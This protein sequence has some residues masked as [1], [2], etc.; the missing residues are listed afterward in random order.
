LKDAKGVLVSNVTTGSAAEKAGIKRG[1]IITAI[2]GEAIEDSNVL[3]NKVAG[4]APGTEIKV[5]V[6]RDGNPQDFTAKLD[7]FNVKG[8]K[9]DLPGSEDEETPREQKET[10]KLGLSLQPV[11]PQ[12]AKQLE[13]P[14]DTQGM[15]VMEVDPD[16]ASAEEGIARGDVILEINRQPVKSPEDVQAALDKSGNRPI[17]LLVTR[18]GTTVYLTVTPKQ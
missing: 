13:L 2:N 9:S 17:L 4:S 7:E 15:V 16:G 14:P 18:Q 6:L 3:R 11:T 12:I 10:G 8:A 1:D 5:T